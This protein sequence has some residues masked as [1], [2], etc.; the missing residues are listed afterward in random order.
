MSAP[1]TRG[2]KVDFEGPCP[3]VPA[4]EIYVLNRGYAG[5]R[6]LPTICTRRRQRFPHRIRPSPWL[7]AEHSQA[8]QGTRVSNCCTEPT[9]RKVVLAFPINGVRPCMFMCVCACRVEDSYRLVRGSLRPS[10]GT[11]RHMSMVFYQ[12]SW[13]SHG[14]NT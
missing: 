3:W 11:N 9:T 12:I 5:S 4:D 13:S 2:P 14:S 1:A 10:H 7:E 8:R 6:L